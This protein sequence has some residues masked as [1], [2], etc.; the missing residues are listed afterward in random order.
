MYGGRR[1]FYSS[2]DMKVSKWRMRWVE[3]VARMGKRYAYTVYCT[4][5]QKRVKLC[6]SFVYCNLSLARTPIRETCVSHI[7]YFT[8][9]C[10]CWYD[11]GTWH[12]SS[13]HLDCVHNRSL[14]PSRILYGEGP[15]SECLA[16]PYNRD[17]RTVVWNCWALLPSVG[18]FC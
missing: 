3:H 7:E 10:T 2:S 1:D 17:E 9:M 5:I 11:Y 12:R 8:S 18:R 13:R 14:Q 15:R 6:S 4:P 16:P